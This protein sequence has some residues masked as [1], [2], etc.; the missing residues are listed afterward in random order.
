MGA[1]LLLEDG[2]K[3][4]GDA[5]GAVTTKVGEAVFNTAMSGYQEVLSDPSYA[6]QVVAMTAPHIGNTGVNLEDPESERV[7]PAAFVVRSLTR[8]P[9]SWRSRGGLNQYLAQHGVPGMQGL[10]TRALVRH[11]RSRGAMKCVVS[12]DG[13]SEDDLRKRLEAWP[14]MTGRDLASEVSCSAPYVYADPAEARL[15][16]A[17]IDGG[18]KQ[19]ILRLLA[20]A[21]CYVRVH[22]LHDPASTIMEG[23]DAVLVSNGPGDPAAIPG[24]VEELKT[25]MGQ[26]P[27]V[28]ICLGNQLLG[29][30][31]GA[32]TYK[33]KFGHRG[34][35]QPV[36]DLRTGKI[37]ITSQNHGFAVDEASL[38]AVGAE[39]THRHLNDQ[40][41]SGFWHPAKRVF[42]VQY[43]PEACPGPRD[44]ESILL[45]Q[46]I[47]FAREDA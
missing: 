37:E 45:E 23:V 21:G 13:T 32:T 1:I 3:F 47:R 27:L 22:P 38:I 46:F 30:A 26:R 29:L 2:R 35:N 10:D 25:I 34:A 18:V 17:V 40:T 16:I 5:F 36:K 15:R 14:G 9:S 7:W 33:L 39:V 20:Q 11:L 44:S 42:A 41:V 4:T 43:H 8:A 28:G 19:N 31:L 12:T 6:E 24:V